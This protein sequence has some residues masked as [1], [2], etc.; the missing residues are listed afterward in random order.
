MPQQ[1]TEEELR[2]A[3]DAALAAFGGSLTVAPMG[4][5]ALTG[6]G[7]ATEGVMTVNVPGKPP[8]QVYRP[9][10][11][12]GALFPPQP[13]TQ[14]VPGTEQPSVFDQPKS[15]GETV[16]QEGFVN[17]AKQAWA[18]F[19]GAG[20]N[21]MHLGANLTQAINQDLTDMG[22]GPAEQRKVLTTVENWFRGQQ[23]GGEQAAA[24]LAGGR[25]D[26][27]S[28]FNRALAGGI[29]NAPAYVAASN[30]LGAAVGM[31]AIGG[32]QN[33]DKGPTAT[34]RGMGEGVLYGTVAHVMG[35]AGRSIRLPGNAATAY[36]Q[37]KKEGASE[38]EAW[39]AAFSGGIMGEMGPG[40]GPGARYMAR[41]I[42][43]VPGIVAESIRLPQ[44][45]NV[46]TP[47]DRASQQFM[48][49]RGIQTPLSMQTGSKAAAALEGTVQTMPGGGGFSE[50]METAKSQ[51]T[52]PVAQDVLGQ[53]YPERV[54]PEEVGTAVQ[55]TIGKGLEET[56]AGL[57]EEVLPGQPMTPGTAGEALLGRGK[58]EIKQF[59]QAANEA[60]E[61]ARR[62]GQ[63]PG[64]T[65]VVPKFDE[66]GKPVLD[67]Q[68]NQLSERMVLPID[69]S[70]VQKALRPIAE[71]YA[72]TLSETDARASLGLKVLRQMINRG[73]FVDAF[74]AELD[75]GM[76]LDALRSEPGMAE[77]RGASGGMTAKAVAE[78]T[79]A[80]D[81]K[82]A[83]ARYP[84]WDGAGESPALRHLKSGRLNTAKKYEVADLFKPYGKDI[85]KVEPV[86]LSEQ[87]TAGRDVSLEQLRRMAEK[88][89]E[90]MPQFGRAFIEDGGNWDSLGPE[91]KKILF[92]DPGIIKGLD[93]YYAKHAKFGP[94]L[95]LE[96]VA[97]FDRITARGGK[98]INLMEEV[99]A[100]TPEH[101]RQIA[102]AFFEGLLERATREGDIQK[103]QGTL[104]KVLDLDEKTLAILVDDPALVRNLKNLFVS[105]KRLK[106][107]PN[108]SGSGFVMALNQFKGNIFKG[109]GMML[110]GTA[111]YGSHGM[112]AMGIG[113]GAGYLAG[114]ATEYGA[115]A[116]LAHLLFN[117]KFIN[118]LNRGIKAELQGDNASG[119][120]AAKT[121][122]KIIEE[123]P[124]EG[125]QGPPE[126]PGTPPGTPP[127][128][129]G[130]GLSREA[131]EAY[132]YYG[133]E[134]PPEGPGGTPGE[135]RGA[136][137]A[138]EQIGRGGAGTGKGEPL[139]IYDSLQKAGDEAR[140]RFRKNM[141]TTMQAGFGFYGG[142]DVL[143]TIAA[144]VAKGV[145]THGAKINAAVKDMGEW[146][147]G[148]IYG[149]YARYPE[150]KE[151]M[152]K[153]AG[154][155]SPEAAE[156]F[157]KNA[158][159]IYASA[160]HTLKQR[161]SE[162][163]G[164]AIGD[165]KKIFEYADAGMDAKEWYDHAR[166][167]LQK[168]FGPHTDLFLHF[169]AATSPQTKVAP[170]VEQ[171]MKA[172]QEHIA[173][174]PFSTNFEAHVKNLGRAARGEPLEGPKVTSFIANLLGDKIRVTVDTWM[175]QA[176][177]LG[178]R[179]KAHLEALARGE[180]AKAGLSNP[181]Y[182]FLDYA[183]TQAARQ[184]GID[185][186]QM[187]AAIWVGIKR[188]EGNPKYTH[189]PFGVVVRDYLKANP[190]IAKVIRN[191]VDA[192]KK[193]R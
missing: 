171:A 80:I 91:T 20:A 175:A 29:A 31:G 70:N 67:D 48:T 82:M 135:Q 42:P 184:R 108:P 45:R 2:R 6:F 57:A 98:R 117:Q 134:Y 118:M 145:K 35:P 97:L 87:I 181:Q 104:D 138:A 192:A 76:L 112:P 156:F 166:P 179:S 161:M 47:Q 188:M 155:L 159:R 126:G 124:P 66:N 9:S 119:R 182:R 140:E 162:M 150:W 38:E 83:Q 61:A 60:Y 174:R 125:P 170:N 1:Q 143:T 153:D 183:V 177:G 71:R 169:L 59:D 123:N 27:P 52:G 186:R 122:K 81:A 185:P 99:A 114:A 86:R 95:K 102:R 113:T 55:R 128:G 54:T 30:P 84:G 12:P 129:G 158:K 65:E 69:L 132:D 73:P 51:L 15:L 85:E 26:F 147:A 50:K 37:A 19:T 44:V 165:V 103:V 18:S 100:E 141:G 77:L 75:R 176:Y 23:A 105:M 68:G 14:Q 39:A 160:Q 164:D 139:S 79:A 13:A 78:L 101:K 127:V 89:P 178:I 157:G 17:P 163:G 190:D 137:P 58:Q 121:L 88:F 168:I 34:L 149:G 7:G 167:Q 130:A 116:A 180:D 32:L 136:P 193:A 107:T 120:L 142:K 111:G 22:L 92:K 131:R 28:Q 74:T 53:I 93:E 36:S 172:F 24:Q 63:H 41:N 56:R 110:G 152:L 148:R 96:P 25:T 133:I 33:V 3:E 144:D 106:A 94:L 16:V 189:E 109:L 40:G 173:G 49:E 90:Q 146:G 62:A 4:P 187:Q 5:E 191:A 115:N 43:K 154:E 11:E 64:N 151:Q 46:L 72:Y 10:S 21:L 8:M